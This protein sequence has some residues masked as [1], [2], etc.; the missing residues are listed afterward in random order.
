MRRVGAWISV[1]GKLSKVLA[2][3]SFIRGMSQRGD[4]TITDEDTCCVICLLQED[5]AGGF[6]LRLTGRGSGSYLLPP[7]VSGC[8]VFPSISSRQSN[9]QQQTN[10]IQTLHRNEKRTRLSTPFTTFSSPT[11]FQSFQQWRVALS[12]KEHALW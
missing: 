4:S 6:V 2:H 11:C 9:A 8:I 5:R 12:F 7:N 10:F 1:A 3:L